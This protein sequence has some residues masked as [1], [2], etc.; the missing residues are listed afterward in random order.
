LNSGGPCQGPRF[1]PRCGSAP[2]AARRRATRTWALVVLV[3][4]LVPGVAQGKLLDLY[5]GPRLGVMQGWGQGLRGL[6]V[7]VEVGAEL[8]FF[9]LIADYHTVVGG[10]RSGASMTELLLGLDGDFALDDTNAL[11][12]RLGGASGLGL[13]T[14]R[15]RSATGQELS[16]KGLILRG[17]LAIERRLN[18]FVIVG[19]ELTGGYHYFLESG[20]IRQLTSGMA[21]PEGGT[22]AQDRWVSGG[23]FAGLITLRGHFEPFQ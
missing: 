3:A 19:F 16:Y 5:A 17:T 11:F 8:L 14:P 2:A 13:L 9:D 7:G 6:G 21:V 10:A 1:W 22:A 15:T 4:L 23:H 12:L 18:R 20:L